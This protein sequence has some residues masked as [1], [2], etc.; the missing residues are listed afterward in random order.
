MLSYIICAIALGVVTEALA[1]ALSLW[2]YRNAWMR[3]PNILIV[4]GLVYGSLSWLVAQQGLV[5]QFIPG[6]VIG[7]LYEF[8]NDRW[9]KWWQFP[10]DPWTWLTGQRAVIAVGL[11][12]GFVPPMVVGLVWVLA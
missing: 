1:Y 8:A 6:A 2:W 7:L 10:G 5:V 4:F 3:I 9:L 12:W 11:A